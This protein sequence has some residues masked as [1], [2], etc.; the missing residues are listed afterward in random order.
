MGRPNRVWTVSDAK[1]R[2]S[3]V[4]RRAATEGPQR[5]GV[6][7][8]FVVVPAETWERMTAPKDETLPLGKWLV[9]HM[10][11]GTELPLPSRQE[12]DRP[13]PFGEHEE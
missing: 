13:S 3:E 4:L 7:K 10:P 1:A 12:T 6:E 5:I 8:R 9:T 2:L 11:R